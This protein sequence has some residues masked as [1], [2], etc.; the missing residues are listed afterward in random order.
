MIHLQNKITKIELQ[1]RNK[2]RVNVFIDEEYAFACSCELI[3]S[4]SLKTGQCIDVQYTKEIVEEDNYIS[5]KNHALKYIER[6]I[7][8]EKEIKDKLSQKEY[9]EY[10]INRVMDFLRQYNFAS[11]ERYAEMYIKEKAKING[12]N[13]I[14]FQLLKKGIREELVKEKIEHITNEED[15]AYFLAE[16]KY[17]IL[18]K[19]ETNTEKLCKKL[20]NY[21]LR[22]GFDYSDIKVVINKIIY[23]ESIE[24]YNEC[25]FFAH[26]KKNYENLHEIAI[27]RH[28]ILMKSEKDLEKLYRKL[29]QYLIRRGFAYDD[30]KMELKKL[31]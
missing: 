26:K 12:K 3:F 4:H 28:A 21:L 2:N 30:V 1:K 18:L 7:K 17:K 27:K 23:S 10:T 19:N 6:S 5:A 29:W 13:K 25:N 8:T 14:K 11:D 15:R 20:S 22:I 24:N 16:K 9:S 31:I